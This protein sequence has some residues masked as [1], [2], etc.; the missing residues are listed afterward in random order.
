MLTAV[1][2]G[3]CA[4][5]AAEAMPNHDPELR[6]A[7]LNAVTTAESFPDRF[8]AEVWLMDMQSRLESMKWIKLRDKA[9]QLEFLRLVHLEASRANISAEMVLA[10]IQVESAFDRFA[11]SRVGARGYMQIMPFWKNEIG[12]DGD[13]LMH[14]ATNLR[15]GCTILRHYLDKEK[16]NWTRALARYN[17]SLGRTVYP[18]KVMAAWEKYWFVNH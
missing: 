2:S 4:L 18:E 5:S 9:E 15:Y 7:L 17:G 8:D 16:G 3:H 10:V 1:L 6:L 13:N 12:R 11:V 14:M